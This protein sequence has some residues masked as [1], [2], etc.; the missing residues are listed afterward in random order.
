[1]KINVFILTLFVV[2]IT[3][4]SVRFL[5]DNDFARNSI[6]VHANI[7]NRASSLADES[8]TIRSVQDVRV[9]WLLLDAP[10]IRGASAQ[11]TIAGDSVGT[12]VVNADLDGYD[13]PPGEYMVRIYAYGN[14]GFGNNVRRIIHRPI[15]IY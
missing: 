10:Y 7:D 3:M 8:G 15:M 5:D 14:D 11:R 12:R 6:T 4:G 9:K 1:M 13:L 2:T